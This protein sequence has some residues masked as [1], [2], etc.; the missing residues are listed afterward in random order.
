MTYLSFLTWLASLGPKL[1]A[2][3]KFVQDLIAL[4]SSNQ[5][6]FKTANRSFKLKAMKRAV[7]TAKERAAESKVLM[8]MPKTRA[9]GDGKILAVIQQL[10]AF[11]KA[12]PALWAL[13]L[14]MLGL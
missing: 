9:I 4:I 2:I 13:I 11:V 5:E 6:L 7:S 12:N 10:Y 14:K 1:P 8:L 3:L